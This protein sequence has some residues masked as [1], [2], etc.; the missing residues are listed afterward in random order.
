MLAFCTAQP[1]QFQN[2]FTDSTVK[3]NDFGKPIVFVPQK[4]DAIHKLRRISRSFGILA[5]P[6]LINYIK[7]RRKPGTISN[8]HKSHTGT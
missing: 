5:L 6:E 7:D 1:R 4:L 2:K 3:T 8:F